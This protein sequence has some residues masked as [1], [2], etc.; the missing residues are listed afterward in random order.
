M[1]FANFTSIEDG[2][3]GQEQTFDNKKVHLLP[4]CFGKIFSNKLC[5]TYPPY[6]FANL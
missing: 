5:K 4:T 2:I 6:K 1:D 3:K